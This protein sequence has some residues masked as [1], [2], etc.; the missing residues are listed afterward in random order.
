MPGEAAYGTHEA[1]SL[2]YSAE[3]FVWNVKMLQK[4]R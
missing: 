2:K 1:W 4:S 3:A